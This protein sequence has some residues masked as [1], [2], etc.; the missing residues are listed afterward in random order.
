MGNSTLPL[1]GGDATRLS[2]I[3][4]QPGHTFLSGDVVRADP[5]NAGEYILAQADDAD[6]AEAVGL[7]ESVAG[8]SFELV[9]QGRLD[10]SGVAALSLAAAQPTDGWVDLVGTPFAT[11]GEV[12]FLSDA[13]EG[14]LTRTPPSTAGTVIKAMIVVTDAT[15]GA[16]E[17]ILT[18]YVGVQIGGPNTVNISEIQPLGS[19]QPWA[20]PGSSPVPRGWALCD[21]QELNRT[22][23]VE[24]FNLI[25]TDYGVGDG[26]TTFNVPDLRGRAAIGFDG[27]PAGVLN[28][29]N[30]TVGT[31]SGEE[32][33]ILTIQELPDHE[34]TL[35]VNFVA[36]TGGVNRALV[37][38][39]AGNGGDV[40]QG[41]TPDPANLP[42]PVPGNA[43]NNMQPLLVINFIIRTTQLASAALLDH[44]IGGHSDVD[45][46]ASPVG[47][48]SDPN[49]CDVLKFNAIPDLPD[50]PNGKWEA[51]S[52]F[53][54]QRNK[55]MNGQFDIWQRTLLLPPPLVAPVSGLVGLASDR[56]SWQATSG[57]GTFNLADVGM[58]RG[59]WA[60]PG[61]PETFGIDGDPRHFMRWQSA[62]AGTDGSAASNLVQRIERVE[63]FNGRQ[64][65]LSFWA[66]TESGTG[67]IAVSLLQFFGAGG[68]PPVTLP[69]SVDIFLTT[70]WTYYTL[71]FAIPVIAGKTVAGGND[72]L[73]VRFHNHID[74]P[75]ATALGFVGPIAFTDVLNLTNVQ[76]EIGTDAS[77]YETQ[78]EETVL[79]A[80]QRYYSKSYIQSIFAGAGTA[81]TPERRG[82]IY[83][84]SDSNG[85]GAVSFTYPQTMRNAPT[86]SLCS[87]AGVPFQA[88][89]IIGQTLDLA[90]SAI[91]DA[92]ASATWFNQQPPLGGPLSYSFQYT[93]DAEL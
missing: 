8:N 2:E 50:F 51:Q 15:V 53:F 79:G 45:P 55:V 62:L 34:I 16:E 3:I 46:E 57:G 6:R 76:L 78:D 60:D 39:G 80:C 65:T 36:F 29:G 47:L 22:T 92:R 56:W 1:G 61:D 44:G 21:G 71:T 74:A 41:F 49:D 68:S 70:T 69:A 37:P 30:D 77:P 25:G 9:Y 48:P 89:D 91:G 75:I 63:H 67:T 27:F 28:P 90:L 72:S 81:I 88:F 20:A 82:E 84:D 66:R 59:D 10:L 11:V 87:T 85:S 13:D 18:G 4:L 86:V 26:S 58:A 12:W 33:H 5:S 43:H 54:S 73:R 14:D 52:Q 83:V 23:F 40:P 42:N 93:A 24:L 64:A 17:G 32:N 7:V 31:Q 35:G 38:L 19:I